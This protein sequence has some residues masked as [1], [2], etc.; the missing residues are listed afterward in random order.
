LVDNVLDLLVEALF[1]ACAVPGPDVLYIF[2]IIRAI[3][4]C[5]DKQLRANGAV[6][7]DDVG[8]FAVA[9]VIY[10]EGHFATIQ[11]VLEICANDISNALFETEAGD[12]ALRSVEIDDVYPIC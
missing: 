3:F 7:L 1:I 10:S 9:D 4:Y 11:L 5:V 6:F 12:A 2:N 8:I